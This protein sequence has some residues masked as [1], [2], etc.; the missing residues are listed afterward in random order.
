M[1]LEIGTRYDEET[2]AFLMG[3]N[4]CLV[5]AVTISCKKL[6]NRPIW[7][8]S[9]FTIR[10]TLFRYAASQTFMAIDVDQSTRTLTCRS[11]VLASCFRF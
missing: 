6:I 5:L 8:T 9:Q 1:S 11:M 3:I 4:K 10:H 7:E 2:G